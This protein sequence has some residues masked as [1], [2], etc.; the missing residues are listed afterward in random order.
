ML[1]A[2]FGTPTA[3]RVLLYMAYFEEGYAGA[4]ARMFRLPLFSVQRQLR[5]F[6]NSRILVS[7]RQ[8]RI[9]MFQF[10]PR[11]PAIEELRAL[12]EKMIEIMPGRESCNLLVNKH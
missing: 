9:R 7:S 4:I 6:E 8:G 10:N 1:R 12:L 2:L 11:Y 5:K 3:E